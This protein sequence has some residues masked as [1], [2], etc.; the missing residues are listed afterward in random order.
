MNLNAAMTLAPSMAAKNF[1][2]ARRKK[3]AKTGAAKPD[4]S[5]PIENEQD[6]HNAVSDFH[7]ASG[8]PSDKAHI[9]KRA[10][11]LGMGDP[12]QKDVDSA[13]A[14]LGFKTT[15]ESTLHK[16]GRRV[17]NLKT[18]KKLKAGGPGSGRHA[19]GWDDQKMLGQDRAERA[20]TP[21]QHAA[22][23]NFHQARMAAFKGKTDTTSRK[24]YEAHRDAGSE[25]SIASDAGGGKSALGAGDRANFL[26]KTAYK[27]EQGNW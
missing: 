22:A 13:K 25:H 7:R 1:S 9:A 5:Y 8:S 10:K 12:F 6:V 23:A 17:G 2:D 20:S 24:A 15:T 11:A 21:A 18:K 16:M 26:S 14:H 19:E 27:A 3:L 4:G